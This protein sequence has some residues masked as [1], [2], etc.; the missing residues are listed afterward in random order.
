RAPLYWFSDESEAG[1][2]NLDPRLASEFHPWWQHTAAHSAELA[3]QLAHAALAE[4]LHHPLHLLKLLQQPVDVLHLGSGPLSD[5]PLARAVDDLRPTPLGRSHGIDD[6]DLPPNVFVVDLIPDRGG[7][8]AHAGQLLQQPGQP[9][10]LADLQQLLA[11]V[12]QIEALP[13]L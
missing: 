6:G 9:A 8:V 12:L 1:E 7:N 4:L 5:A 11:E 13:L 10:H 3:H 2:T